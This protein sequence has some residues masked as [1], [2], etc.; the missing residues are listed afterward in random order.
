MKNLF[1][2]IA[3]LLLT[4]ACAPASVQQTDTAETYLQRGEEAFEKGRYSEAI[5]NWEKIR[6]SYYSPEMNSL[7]EM[8]IADAYYQG[9][10]YIEASAAYEDF[11]RQHPSHTRTSD[12]LYK[13]GMSYFHQRLS[14]DRDQTSSRNALTAFNDLLSR[15][16]DHPQKAEV[17]QNIHN[18]RDRLAEAEIMVGSFY[19]RTKKYKAAIGR[20]EDALKKHPTYSKQ[21]QA[22]FDLGRAYL[23]IN[24]KRRAAEAF[25]ALY[26]N[27]PD[28][29]YLAKAQKLVEKSF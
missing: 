2:L 6:D 18:C 3:L 5:T 12:I 15:F 26:H 7:A 29:E 9:E 16:P 11:L 27:F 4:T 13:L 1:T 23:A 28:S 22:Y 24:E 20:L 17:E 14:P 21:D 25:N 8:K 19:L 10:Q